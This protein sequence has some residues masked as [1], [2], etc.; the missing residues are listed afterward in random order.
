VFFHSF[1]IGVDL[2]LGAFFLA[3]VFYWVPTA[4]TKKELGAFLLAS[5][6]YWVPTAQTKKELGAYGTNKKRN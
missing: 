5:V 2:L 3:S 1:F 6:F 4:Q